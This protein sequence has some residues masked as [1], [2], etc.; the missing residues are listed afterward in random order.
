MA[1]STELRATCARRDLAD[2][3]G[4]VSRGARRRAGAERDP[5][6]A[7][8][9]GSPV[10]DTDLPRATFRGVQTKSRRRTPLT[11]LALPPDET[12]TLAHE[13]G[14]ASCRSR[15]HVALNVYSAEDSPPPPSG[16]AA[17]DAATPRRSV[18]THPPHATS[19]PVLTGS[20][21]LQGQVDGG[22]RLYRLAVKVTRSSIGPR[23]R[24]DHPA[25]ASGAAR[26]AAGADECSS[27]QEYVIF[28]LACLGG[29]RIDGQ[30][31]LSGFTGDVR[32]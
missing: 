1:T 18:A 25:R 26:L 4:V 17:R 7:E 14:E 8:G 30:F 6:G 19:T 12:V 2:A 13:E 3:L 9:G 16:G 32:G 10:T 24:R 20:A 31:E 5:A 28:A 21:K 15:S 23:P 27:C 11:D 22:D 29:R